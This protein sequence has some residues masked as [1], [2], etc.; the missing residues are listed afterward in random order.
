M[1]NDSILESEKLH[2]IKLFIERINKSNSMLDKHSALAEYKDDEHIQ[3]VLKYTYD[4]YMKYYVTPD[5]LE[6]NNGMLEPHGISDMF[7]MLD[8]LNARKYTGNIAISRVNSYIADNFLHKDVIYAVLDRNLKINMGASEINKV[9]PGLIPEFDVA[10]AKTFDREML[11]PNKKGKRKVDFENETWYASHKLDGCRCLC[12]IDLN[13]NV[14]FKS[15]KGHDFNTLDVLKKEIEKWEL[16]DVVLDGEMCIMDAAG[17]EDFQAIMREITR[18]DHTISHPRYNVF[19]M[20]TI[21]EFEAGEGNTPLS[22]RLNNLKFMVMVGQQKSGNNSLVNVLSQ[23][24][25][26]SKAHLDSLLEVVAKNG[27]EGLMLRK[28]VG[29]EGKRTSNLL[30]LKD[31]KDAEY[32][33]VG[34]ETDSITG[35]FYRDCMYGKDVYFDFDGEYRYVETGKRVYDD[36]LVE[37]YSDTRE[38]VSKLVIVH[39]GNPVGVGSGLSMRQ[40]LEWHADNSKIIGKTVT[41]Q[42]FQETEVD[43]RMSLRFPVLKHKY[44][45]ERDV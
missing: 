29:Y 5:N 42:Y 28:D 12:I 25:V 13:G 40:R 33:V 38:M 14:S 17:N 44:D 20:L 19:D 43:G 1:T 18:K 8:D 2:S 4:P 31:M 15:R 45:G 9:F 6:K 36:N 39:K 34:L 32:E 10:L 16:R 41:I 30:K 26:K 37:S 27:W 11:E 24:I 3:R 7:Q 21:E 35:I 23:G 22:T